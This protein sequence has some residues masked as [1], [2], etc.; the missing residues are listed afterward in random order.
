MNKDKSALLQPVDESALKLAAQLLAQSP[1]AALAVLEPGTG[2][3]MVSRVT[4]ACAADG[5]PL[6]LLSQLSAHTQA[7]SSDPRCSL[8]LGE[9]GSGDPLAHPRITVFGQAQP[10]ARD[11][12]EH[13][14]LRGRFLARHPK[15]AFYADFGDFGFWRLV[16]YGAN[17]NAGF[18]RAYLIEQAPLKVALRLAADAT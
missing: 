17:M 9:P 18:G 7:L 10:V 2:Y 8:L 6:L 14:Q 11:A 1:L 4:V 13:A 15:A 3:P 5:T 12:P 16:A